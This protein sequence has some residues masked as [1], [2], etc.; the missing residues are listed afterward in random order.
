VSSLSASEAYRFTPREFERLAIYR[1]AVRAGYF[2]EGLPSPSAPATTE[3]DVCR[4]CAIA[5]ANPHLP[6]LTCSV[7]GH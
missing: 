2:N 4:G 1:Q 6:E 3:P 5:C 7:C